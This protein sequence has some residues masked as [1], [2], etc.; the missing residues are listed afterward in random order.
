M[1]A[2]TS[3]A[4]RGKVRTYD[5][6]AAA[7]AGVP[8]RIVRPMDLEKLAAEFEGVSEA[9]GSSQTK[10]MLETQELLQTINFNLGRQQIHPELESIITD[11]ISQQMTYDPYKEDV[12]SLGLII[13]QLMLICNQRDIE[14]I[15]NDPDT[16]KQVIVQNFLGNSGQSQSP[17]SYG[18]P[19]PV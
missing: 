5:G 13:L 7:F 16:L 17:R 4:A 18:Q 2:S 1:P 12:F 3:R 9:Y 11:F 8:S 15:G 14:A 10:L 19:V 6:L